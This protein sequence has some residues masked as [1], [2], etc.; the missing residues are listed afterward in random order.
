MTTFFVLMLLGLFS[1]TP[2]A[3]AAGFACGFWALLGRW[4]GGAAGGLRRSPGGHATHGHA[5]ETFER[6]ARERGIAANADRLI[7]ETEAY[8]RALAGAEEEETP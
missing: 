2:L 4:R 1:L 5:S 6:V 8:L 3:V 7:A